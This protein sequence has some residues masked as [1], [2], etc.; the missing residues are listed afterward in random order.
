M[1]RQGTGDPIRF[2]LCKKKI[3][4]WATKK[5]WPHFPWNP[6]CLIGI[7][8]KLCDNPHV[9]RS[10]IPY[11]PSTTRVFFI[12]QVMSFWTKYVQYIY[13]FT[14]S[15]FKGSSGKNR[16]LT[17]TTSTLSNSTPQGESSA[18]K[19]EWPEMM[20]YSAFEKKSLAFWERG[21]E[22]QLFMRWALD[23]GDGF[24]GS[25]CHMR[26]VS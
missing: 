9:V 8:V 4:R 6:G 17:R 22:L 23:F 5:K 12:A 10:T 19:V 1:A 14:Q 26:I 24:F 2:C 18:E 25:F 15:P 16:E 13:T 3:P 11:I 7:L 20:T 21:K